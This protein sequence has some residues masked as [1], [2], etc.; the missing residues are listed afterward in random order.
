VRVVFVIVAFAF[1]AAAM[2]LSEMEVQKE[3]QTWQAKYS[4]SYSG[5]EVAIR[6]ANFK[7]S[8]DIVN[9]CNAR[10]ARGETSFTCGKNKFMDLSREEF[11]VRRGFRS[12][13]R[14]H[15]DISNYVF[16]DVE[17]PETVD[18]LKLGKVTGVK[19]QGQCGSCWA[20][21]AIGAL[22][23]AAAIA[24]NHTWAPTDDATGFS[25]Q[26]VV[27][28]D[29]LNQDAGCDGGDMPS[30]MQYIQQNKGVTAE[31]LYQYTAVDGKCRT[32][33]ANVSIGTL[34]GVYMIPTNNESALRQAAS[35]Q[36]ISVAIDASCDDFQYYED[37]VFDISCGTSLDHGVLVTGYEFNPSRHLGYWVVKNSWGEDWGNIGYIWMA[38]GYGK[39]GI[40]GITLE[41]SIPL[42]T[43]MPNP[44]SP[45]KQ[46]GR[47]IYA[48]FAPSTCC[49]SNEVFGVCQ[50]FVCCD[51]S[52]P[53]C[54]KG[55][56]CSKAVEL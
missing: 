24:T 26:Q 20:F 41:P 17:V 48:C 4:K 55:K 52:A 23:G 36:P 47:G 56:G 39:E 29:H 18:W 43:N 42:K 10:H 50:T 19:D 1:V 25:E 49:C 33:L 40:C 35:M 5:S 28:C 51:S 38:M 32:Q 9:N 27:D 22:E 21:S 8:L 44:Y 16:K 12:S 45:P 15:E 30:A 54:T 3:F 13:H 6:Y 14:K 7:R 34:D 37:G 2:A 46:C 31:E 53:V 11:A